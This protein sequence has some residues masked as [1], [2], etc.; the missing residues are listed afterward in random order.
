MVK[1]LYNMKSFMSI[2]YL[3]CNSM[4]N[5]EMYGTNSDFSLLAHH[6]T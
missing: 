5:M 4:Q 1:Q 3:F 6:L 2:F